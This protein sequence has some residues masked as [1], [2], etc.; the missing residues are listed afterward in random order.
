MDYLNHIIVSNQTYFIL[1]DGEFT[2]RHEN[3]EVLEEWEDYFNGNLKW[4][5]HLETVTPFESLIRN[6]YN[7][8]IAIEEDDAGKFQDLLDE[9]SELASITVEEPADG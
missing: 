5:E 3:P 8:R 7:R 6:S 9:S 2:V 1:D 4:R